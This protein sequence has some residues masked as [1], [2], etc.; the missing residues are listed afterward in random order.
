MSTPNEYHPSGRLYTAREY[1]AR[2]R[3][4]TPVYVV[5]GYSTDPLARLKQGKLLPHDTGRNAAKKAARLMGW[6]SLKQ[7]DR[8]NERAAIF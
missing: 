3:A 5:I 7:R 2:R 8:V 4:L 1:V 6:R